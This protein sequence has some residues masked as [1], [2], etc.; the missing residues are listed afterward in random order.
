MKNDNILFNIFGLKELFNIQKLKMTKQQLEQE[1]E[2]LKA[3]IAGLS[4]N[5]KTTD[6]KIAMFMQALEAYK[7]RTTAL[8]DEIRLLR[9][10]NQAAKQFNDQERNY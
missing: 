4:F 6:D 1:N 5:L 2:Q 10:N 9:V 3:Q 7:E 8:E